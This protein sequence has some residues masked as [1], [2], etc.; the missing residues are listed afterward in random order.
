VC[1]LS[2]H[3]SDKMLIFNA[4]NNKINIDRRH[5]RNKGNKKL[6]FKAGKIGEKIGGKQKITL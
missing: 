1:V 2:I 6:A 4:L 3:V 5:M